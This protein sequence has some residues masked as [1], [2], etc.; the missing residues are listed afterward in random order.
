MISP[1]DPPG[2]VVRTE[3]QKATWDNGYRLGRGV[4]SGWLHYAST[5]A[6]GAVWI[7][8]VSSHGPWLLSI[9][10][11][12]VAAEIGA[13][14]ASPVGGP[15]LITFQLS[16]LRELHAV[17]DRVY[18]LAVSLPDA[19]LTRFRV[20]TKNLPQ[21]TEAERLVVQRVGQDIFREALMDYWGGRCPMTGI[22][23]PELLR[24]SH[25]VPWADSTDEQR[26][27][28]YN[29]L[30]LSALWDAAF[31]CG[32]ISFADDGSILVTDQI[33]EATRAAL[34]ITATTRLNGLRDQH[35]ANLAIH[36][37]R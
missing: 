19:P 21:S 33:G 2:F 16:T 3:A 29:G 18:K 8:G 23:E 11:S 32:L 27:D 5:T 36:R 25:I 28:V 37:E 35:R 17:L 24:A 30:L 26:L 7:A 13:L 1:E 22:T 6:P 15:G 31:D 4:E 14:P 12:G 34:G 20:K 9:D 10:H